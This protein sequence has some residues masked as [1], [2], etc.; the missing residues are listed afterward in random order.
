MLAKSAKVRRFEQRI[1]QFRQNRL[2][3]VDQKRIYS[4]F[5]GG[6]GRSSDDPNAEES[7]RFWGNIWSIEKEH[8]QEAE[9]LKDLKTGSLRVVMHFHAP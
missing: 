5:N 7:K 2:F 8:N 6:R 4:E 1:E 9:W 3:S